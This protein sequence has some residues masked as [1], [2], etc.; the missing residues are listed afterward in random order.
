MINASQIVSANL[1]GKTAFITGASGGLGA[2]FAALL[3]RSGCAVAIGARR[4]DARE[5]IARGI[6]ADGGTACHVE[7]DV[8][9]SESVKLAVDSVQ[10]MI[11]AIDVLI[12][13]S[14]ISSI[15]P[16]LEHTEEQ[17]DAVIDTNLKGAFLVSTEVARR[18]RD[19]SNGGAIIN[20]ASILAERQ[21]NNVAS[22]A[23]SKAGLVQLTK[24][25]ALELARFNI[26]V[27]AL[28]PGYIDT[29]INHEL[30][31]TAAG[32]ALIRRIPQ[33]RL[34]I[35][36]DLDGAMLLLA[37]ESSRFMTGAV[38]VVDGGHL[39]NTL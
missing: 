11:G 30:W 21:Q 6:V 32:E 37:S 12:N 15:G 8:T 7:I 1:S 18:M 33:R 27:N 17:W 36:E 28:S 19:A 5:K 13:N 31:A 10:N 35:M 22:Y 29:E 20:I 34:G 3:A 38:I 14:G 39:V 26:R 2:H 24:S 23:V 16:S 4:F 25:M 9:N